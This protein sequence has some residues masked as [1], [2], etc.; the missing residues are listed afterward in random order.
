MRKPGWKHTLN[1]KD[2]FHNDEVSATDRQAII[3]DRI[4][5]SKF[6]DENDLELVEIVDELAEAEVGD[7]GPWD[8]FYDWADQNRVWVA[9]R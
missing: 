4:K 7:E 3:V 9:T 8:G 6:W 2:I 1:L 5:R